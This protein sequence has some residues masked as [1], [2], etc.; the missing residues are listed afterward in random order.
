[1][2]DNLDYWNIDYFF[3]IQKQKSPLIGSESLI[4]LMDNFMEL[5]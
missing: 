2:F 1:M 4:V 3:D 5:S